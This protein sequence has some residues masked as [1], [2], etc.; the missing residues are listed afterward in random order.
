M[1]NIIAICVS[2]ISN[3]KKVSYKSFITDHL[4][5]DIYHYLLSLYKAKVKTKKH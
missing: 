2:K 4:T 1:T 3:D 5:I